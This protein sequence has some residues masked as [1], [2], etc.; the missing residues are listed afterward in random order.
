MKT[1]IKVNFII[2]GKFIPSEITCALGVKPTDT[3]RQGDVYKDTL[4]TFK[5]DG[6]ELYSDEIESLDLNGEILKI[7]NLIYPYSFQLK[8]ITK[9]LNLDIEVACEIWV[10]DYQYP[11]IYFEREVL[12]KLVDL[13]AEF[14]ISIY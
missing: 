1:S 11:T 8:E 14:G 5:H 9:R 3:W 6:W 2:T 10:E 13:N 7:I 12:S 4:V